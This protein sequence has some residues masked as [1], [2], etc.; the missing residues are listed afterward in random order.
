M[1]KVRIGIVGAGGAGWVHAKY[2]TWLPGVQVV[3]VCDPIL[4]R[5]TILARKWK[6]PAAYGDY[7]EMF[8]SEALD[9]VSNC[10]PDARHA[11]VSLAAIRRGLPVLSEKPMADSL[12]E[13]RRML[14]AAQEADAIAMLNFTYRYSGA[15]EA[16]ARLIR[17]G[18]LGRI[19]HVEGSCLQSWLSSDYW[20]HWSE[21]DAVWKLS[22][23][24]GNLGALGD[25]GCH[26]MDF[27]TTLCGDIAQVNC[28]LK[29]FPKGVP[30]E[31]ARGFPLDASDS[32][33]VT[34][35]F[36]QG[37]MGVLHATRWA[38]GHAN[39]LRVRVY[40]DRGA[41][42]I[43]HDRSPH[44][45]RVVLGRADR[46]NMRWRTVACRVAPR[47]FERFVKAIRSGRNASPDFA[48]GLRNQL[49]IEACRR[50]DR[51]RRT[52]RVAG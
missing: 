41:L 1:K 15:L 6:V 20:G 3:A 8:E 16:G 9:G 24:G 50:S 39:S 33:A 51:A 13:A 37:G 11:D 23:R 38:T 49:L 47:P 46:T 18:R 14:A 5:R 12:A 27:V 21:P 26:L 29:C 17:A 48:D 52:V 40:G 34:V 32:L 30:G 7:R 42:D 43:D 44:E 19:L 22:S 35:E 10:T 4:E 45:L 2:M 31:T 25:L 28:R 36:A